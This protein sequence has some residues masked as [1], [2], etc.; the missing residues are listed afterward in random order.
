MLRKFLRFVLKH[1]IYKV[2]TP[3]KRT[4]PKTKNLQL[5][6]SEI[7][8]ITLHRSFFLRPRTPQ[9]ERLKRPPR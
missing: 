2:L 6:G 9:V 7:N 1:N 5:N 4:T 8:P 3:A